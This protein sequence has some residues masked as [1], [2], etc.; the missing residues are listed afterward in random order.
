MAII[1]K[2]PKKFPRKGTRGIK[3]TWRD[4]DTT[5]V[6]PSSVKWTL[7]NHPPHDIVPD[8]INSK[9]DVSETPGTTN[10]IVLSGDDLDFLTNEAGE[11]DIDR[12][13]LVEWEYDSSTLGTGITDY[14]EYHFTVQNF[15]HFTV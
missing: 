13:L 10:T 6:T 7:T 12:V 11:D 4:T 3:I 14:F 15:S 1:F 5:P 2:A 9:E 8:V